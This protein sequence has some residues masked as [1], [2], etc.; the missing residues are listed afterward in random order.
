MKGVGFDAGVLATWGAYSDER[1]EFD[2][3]R[4]LW[5]VNKGG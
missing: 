3:F 1:G 4:R 2:A 5:R